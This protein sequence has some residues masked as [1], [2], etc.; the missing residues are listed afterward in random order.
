MIR[1][2]IRSARHA[3]RRVGVV[4]E[5]TGY[6]SV[7]VAITGLASRSYEVWP[8]H[9]AELGADEDGG[10]FLGLAFQVATFGTSQLAGPGRE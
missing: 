6:E 8:R 7:E 9:G 4:V 2:F 1:P 10:T 3:L 5:C